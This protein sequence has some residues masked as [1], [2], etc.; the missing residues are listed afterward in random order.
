MNQQD[1][2]D[3]SDADLWDKL[4]RSGKSPSMAT[5]LVTKRRMTQPFAGPG[6]GTSRDWSP[7]PVGKVEGMARAANQGL[8]F[9]LSDEISASAGAALEKMHGRSFSD[10][11]R[12]R[13]GE[14]RR[15][16]KQFK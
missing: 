9:G 2:L 12:E 4:V 16:D 14:E 10:S 15:R 13:V 7:E 5:A 8:T 6:R 1:D 3:L 11:Y